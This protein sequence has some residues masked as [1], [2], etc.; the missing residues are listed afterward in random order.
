MP[1]ARLAALGLVALGSAALVTHIPAPSYRLGEEIRA[2]EAIRAFLLQDQRIS[3]QWESILD[4]GR[5]EGRS[6]DQLAGQID[7]D[8]TSEY[9]ESFDGLA[10]LHLD[11][12]APSA[13]TLEMLRKYAELRSSASHAL[14]EGLRNRNPEQIRKALET[15]RQAPVLA[16]GASAAAI[17]ASGPHGKR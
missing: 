16:R 17:G 7:A 9:Q 15:A 6:F 4:K 10:A 1:R 11:R 14:S 12:A 8:V 13:A 2:Q 5:S 3:Q